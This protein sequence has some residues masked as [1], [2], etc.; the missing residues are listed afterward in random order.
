MMLYKLTPYEMDY[1]QQPKSQKRVPVDRDQFYSDVLTILSD[2]KIDFLIGGTYALMAHTK[3]DRETKDLDIFC[4]P[5]DH[6]K[7]LD[8]FRAEGYKILVPD[9][10][11]LSKIVSGQNDCDVIFGL[12]NSL[13]TVRDSWFEEV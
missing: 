4:R 6:L 13:I 3:I 9:E 1:S 8:R 12:G 10:R 2:S 7:I 5:G 11:W